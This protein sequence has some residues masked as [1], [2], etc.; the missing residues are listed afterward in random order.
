VA[1]ALLDALLEEAAGEFN[2][3]IRSS[4]KA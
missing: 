3:P 4:S 1:F 2:A